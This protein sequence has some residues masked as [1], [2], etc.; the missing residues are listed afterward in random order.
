MALDPS[1]S[2]MALAVMREG[3]ELQRTV[4]TA[5]MA[6]YQSLTLYPLS[7]E[8]GDDGYEM[9]YTVFQP[10]AHVDFFLCVQ[11]ATATFQK[12]S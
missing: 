6:A 10:E 3:R 11:C 4:L 9:F 7:H 12:T 1:S 5:H 8:I 2:S